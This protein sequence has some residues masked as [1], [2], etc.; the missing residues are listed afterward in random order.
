MRALL[1]TAAF[2]LASGTAAASSIEDVGSGKAVNSSVAAISCASCPPLKP[3]KKSSYV[4]PDLAPGT[5]RVEFKEIGG[6]VK[7]V[8]TEAWLGGS[9]VVFVSKASEDAI[10]A[11]AMKSAQPTMANAATGSGPSQSL[12]QDT[13][14]A[15]IDR[16]ATTAAIQPISR[17]EPVAASMADNSSREFDPSDFALRLD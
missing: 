6:E 10:K 8:R 3:K 5:E 2:A 16:A 14:S 13:V 15:E 9:P 17:A 1:I 7:S 4:V 12:T 11:A